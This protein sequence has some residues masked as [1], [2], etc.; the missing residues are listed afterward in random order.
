MSKLT[1]VIGNKNYS[2]WSLRPWILLKQFDIPFQETLIPLKQPDTKEK[3]LQYSP[4]GKVPVLLHDGAR[5]WE[6]LPICEYVSE[7]FPQKALWP[8]DPVHR[9]WARCI[10]GEMYSGFM[11]LRKNFPQN[12][13][14]N[15]VGQPRDEEADRDIRRVLQIWEEC[16]QNFKGQ[17]EFLFGKFSIADAMFAPVIYRFKTYGI[18]LSG[19]S[20]E[21]SSTMLALP[22]MKEWESA[23]AI[24][25]FPW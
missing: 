7:L 22:A 6:S 11:G 18:P 20:Q 8:L 17:G 16:R 23:A 5:V 14:A 10:S 3:V 13:S 19:L 4:S 15:V 25:K 9:A 21:Y 24:E 2:S 12:I 1:L